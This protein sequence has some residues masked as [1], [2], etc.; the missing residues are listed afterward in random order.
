MPRAALQMAVVLPC[1]HAQ[2]REQSPMRAAVPL[3]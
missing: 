1:S 3:H 2:L